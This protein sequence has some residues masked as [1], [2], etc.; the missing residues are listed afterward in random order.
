MILV[1]VAEA[2]DEADRAGSAAPRAAPLARAATPKS[3]VANSSTRALTNVRMTFSAAICSTSSVKRSNRPRPTNSDEVGG[4]RVPAGRHDEDLTDLS[5]EHAPARQLGNRAVEP[6]R[7]ARSPRRSAPRRGRS[8]RRSAR[9]VDVGDAAEGEPEVDPVL[10]PPAD[11]D[12]SNGWRYPGSVVGPIPTPAADSDG[13]GAAASS[14]AR[15]GPATSSVS[16]RSSRWLSSAPRRPGDRARPQPC[17][18]HRLDCA[19]PGRSAR[20]SRGERSCRRW[21]SRSSTARPTSLL[22]GQAAVGLGDVVRRLDS[23]QAREVE[24]HGSVARRGVARTRTHRR[25]RG[26]GPSAVR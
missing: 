10:P 19:R 16:S 24:R 26:A 18:R 8:R 11:D 7:R 4:D 15:R 21:P 1:R 9:D 23:R 12:C 17:F 6:L 20:M 5:R 2:A 14:S 13:V 22:F 3:T 25:R